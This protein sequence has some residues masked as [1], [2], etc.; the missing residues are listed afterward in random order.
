MV[1]E[2]HEELPKKLEKENVIKGP[3][4]S[5]EIM[6]ARELWVKRAQRNI[7]EMKETLS[8]RL[9]RDECGG[10]LR[11]QG[12]IQGYC[13]ICLE[14]SLF[15]E[16]LIRYTHEK[17]M[18]MGVANTMGALREIWWIPKMRSLVKKVIR[19]C[20]V[21]KVFS[22]NLLVIKK[23]HLCLYFVQP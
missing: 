16:K 17:V 8:W 4:T 20:N 15:A 7:M 11:C 1:F 3:L 10:I 18:H 14:E 2:I 21:C 5:E 6:R 13:P 12:R 22:A 19:N 23:Q 9:V